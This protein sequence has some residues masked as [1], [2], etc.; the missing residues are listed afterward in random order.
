MLD[1]L[2]LQ[3]MSELHNDYEIKFPKFLLFLQKRKSGFGLYSFLGSHTQ[4][5][6]PFRISPTTDDIPKPG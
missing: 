4:R 1:S 3:T 5:G 2:Q 6:Q